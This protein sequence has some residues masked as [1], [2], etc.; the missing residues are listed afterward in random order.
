MLSE[1]NTL[2]DNAIL[3]IERERLLFSKDLSMLTIRAQDYHLFL[4]KLLNIIATGNN[5][6]ESATNPLDNILKYYD[7]GYTLYDYFNGELGYWNHRQLVSHHF[8]TLPIQHKHRTKLNRDLQ[9]CVGLSL[10]EEHI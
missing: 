1:Q 8:N 2:Q 5:H 4:L 6:I 9:I 10:L 3:K 7:N